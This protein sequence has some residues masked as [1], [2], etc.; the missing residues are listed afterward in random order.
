MPLKTHKYFSLNF[1]DVFNWQFSKEIMAHTTFQT[2]FDIFYLFDLVLKG[3]NVSM[4]YVKIQ[5]V[6]MA[7]VKI[8]E[9]QMIDLLTREKLSW[10]MNDVISG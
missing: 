9:V 8:Q 10:K 2:T 3:A 6:S 5:E 4:A 7:C 1:F